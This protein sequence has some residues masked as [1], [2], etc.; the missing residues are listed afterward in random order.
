MLYSWI[1]LYHSRTDLLY[2]WCMYMQINYLPAGGG[3]CWGERGFHGNAV[4]K[5]E[6]LPQSRR[7]LQLMMSQ[8]Q[9]INFV[10]QTSHSL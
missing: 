7:D 10:V 3:R 6:L 4:H 2:L 5:S 8:I 1:Y 9:E